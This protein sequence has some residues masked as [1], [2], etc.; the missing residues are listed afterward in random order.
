M[1]FGRWG[2]GF[3][4]GSELF[5]DSSGVF[6]VFLASLRVFEARF[7]L[8]LALFL[9]NHRLGVGGFLPDESGVPGRSGLFLQNLTRPAR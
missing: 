3:P 5:P 9:F 7:S 2:Y 4:A 6:L 8:V 1:F